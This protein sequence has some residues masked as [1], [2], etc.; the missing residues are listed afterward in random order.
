MVAMSD[1]AERPVWTVTAERSPGGWW[2]LEVPELG[3]VSQTRRL[4]QA[5]DEMREAIAHLAR[6]REDEFDVEVSPIIDPVTRDAMASLSTAR[7]EAEVARD[8]AARLARH[9]ARS[10]RESGLSLRDIGTLM[11]I[12]HQRARELLQTQ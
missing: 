1:D 7:A 5:A 9:I 2:V 8:N 6:M 12:S 10:L 3:A 11:H 4:D